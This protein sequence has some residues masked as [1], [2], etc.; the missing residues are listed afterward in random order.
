MG[1][2]FCHAGDPRLSGSPSAGATRDSDLRVGKAPHSPGRSRPLA[3]WLPPFPGELPRTGHGV[4]PPDRRPTRPGK[5]PRGLKKNALSYCRPTGR[6]DPNAADLAHAALALA[7]LES[8]AR[9]GEIML[10]DEDETILWRFA[11]PRAGWWRRAQR[12]RLLTRPLSPS[13]IKR[14]EA[15][16]RQ[17]W[18]QYRSWSCISS[19]VLLS[20]LGAVQDGTSRVF[21]KIVPHLDAHEL[22]QYLH[23]LMGVFGPTGKEVVLVGDRSGSHRAGKVAST[24]AHYEGQLQFHLLPAHCGHPLNPLEGFWRVMQDAIGAGRCFP[25][26]HQLY[27]R[28]RQVLIAH[29]ERPI[30]EFHW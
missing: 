23:Q 30:C 12:A 16:K 19:G 29:Q 26:L 5:H 8:R 3:P 25:A 2:S 11:L 9:R 14:D 4:G 1:V 18:T 13:Q 10:L 22:R 7:A 17:A 6:L 24:L 15:L 28:T 20:V 27:Q 21:Y